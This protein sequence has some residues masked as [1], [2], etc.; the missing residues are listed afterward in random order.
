MKSKDVN[1]ILKEEKDDKDLQGGKNCINSS[2]KRRKSSMLISLSPS[3]EA[4]YVVN[5]LIAQIVT[6]WTS[7]LNQKGLT[8]ATVKTGGTHKNQFLLAS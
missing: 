5:G 3:G 4:D 7:F 8:F 2:K 1:R 6:S